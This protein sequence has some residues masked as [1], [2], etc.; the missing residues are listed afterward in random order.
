MISKIS[1]A[2]SRHWNE[3]KDTRHRR[4]RHLESMVVYP[5]DVVRSAPKLVRLRN[6]LSAAIVDEE[7]VGDLWGVELED[8]VDFIEEGRK[9]ES[10]YDTAYMVRTMMEEAGCSRE[11]AGAIIYNREIQKL[12]SDEKI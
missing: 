8:A 6:E 11:E 12:L 9:S 3:W 10:F 1:R 5:E 7:T 2:W 4:A